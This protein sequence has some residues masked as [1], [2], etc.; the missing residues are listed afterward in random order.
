MKRKTSARPAPFSSKDTSPPKRFGGKSGRSIRY[1]DAWDRREKCSLHARMRREPGRDLAGVGA[2]PL[3][4][5][6]QCFDPAHGQITFERAHN[7]TDGAR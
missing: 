4:A 5:Q 7:R 2:L 1:R 6:C 3:H